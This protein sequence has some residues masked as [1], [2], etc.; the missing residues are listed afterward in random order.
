MFLHSEGAFCYPSVLTAR[1][2]IEKDG[3]LTGTLG[4]QSLNS[5]LPGPGKNLQLA[6]N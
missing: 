4:V 5:P 1:M 6:D 2:L 3:I